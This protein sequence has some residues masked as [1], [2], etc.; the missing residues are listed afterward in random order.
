MQTRPEA[1][2]T[3]RGI[4]DWFQREGAHRATH[5]VA[6]V[7][8]PLRLL[9]GAA[10]LRQQR[11]VAQESEHGV[12]TSGAVDAA[13][14]MHRTLEDEL[15]ALVAR[16]ARALGEATRLCARHDLVA[17]AG[18]AKVRWGLGLGFGFGFR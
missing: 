9:V 17:G 18:R 11:M 14:A 2:C 1:L 5:A 15:R 7:V 12:P 3:R 6:R 8:G 16:S 4:L 10:A 13:T